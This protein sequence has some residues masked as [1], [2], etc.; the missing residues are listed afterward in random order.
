MLNPS[1]PTSALTPSPSQPF[2]LNPPSTHQPYKHER[3]N[4][5]PTIPTLTP[6]NPIHAPHNPQHQI[7]KYPHERN[8]IQTQPDTVGQHRGNTAM[9]IIVKAIANER[10]QEDNK[11]RGEE[12]EQ[13]ED[14]QNPAVC[15]EL[16]GAGVA[17]EL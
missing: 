6:G 10:Y 4:P 11:R 5:S 3:D 7:R 14:G 16:V 15:I 12:N 8:N 1:N 13:L 17:Y 2:P 9:F